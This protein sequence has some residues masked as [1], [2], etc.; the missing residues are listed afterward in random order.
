[1]G[2]QAEELKDASR[3]PLKDRLAWTL[4]QAASLYGIDYDGL[5]QA[6]SRGDID[7]F[8]P[9]SK[10]GNPARRHVRREEMDR[11]IKTLEE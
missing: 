4:P 5:R 3:I 11:Y 6:V 7:T 9:L 2:I 1:M 8:R 10:R